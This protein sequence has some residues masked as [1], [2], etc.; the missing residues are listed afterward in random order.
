MTR[1]GIPAN[2]LN[3]KKKGWEKESGLFVWLPKAA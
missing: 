2:V 1:L 3:R